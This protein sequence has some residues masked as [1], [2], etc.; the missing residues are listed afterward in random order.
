M[1][2][3]TSERLGRFGRYS[4]AISACVKVGGVAVILKYRH[5]NK[6]RHVIS[7]NSDVK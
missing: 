4:I 5:F 1:Y 2:L 7:A 6:Q 3:V